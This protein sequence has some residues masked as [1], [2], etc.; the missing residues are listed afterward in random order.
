MNQ[1]L[2]PC[3]NACPVHTDVRGYIAAISRRDYREAYRLITAN[4]PFPAVCAWICH[5][6]CEDACRRA[7][8]DV[9][10][11]IRDL[12]RF[13]V[14]TAGCVQ[15]GAGGAASTG[16]KVAVI[17]GGPAG[18]TAAYD[19]VK[20]GH[21]VI[22]YERHHSPGGHFLSSLPTYRL[23]REMLKRDIEKILAA[24]VEVRTGT[25]IGV[26][27]TVNSLIEEF[28]AV[29]IAAGLWVS[30]GLDLPGLDHPG[31]HPALQ[32]LEKANRGDMSLAGSRVVVIGGGNVAFD[33][34][35]TAVRIG[36][37]D[38]TV[39]CLESREEIPAHRREVDEA[40]EEG[41]RLHPGYGPVEVLIREGKITGTAV[42][43]VRSIYGQD[44]KFNPFL[45]QGR[46]EIIPCDAVVLAVGQVPDLSLLKGSG[47]AAGEKDFLPTDR[48]PLHP[49]APKVFACGEIV[50]GPGLAIAAVASGHRV[51]LAADR[52]LKGDKTH[53]E[54]PVYEVIAPLP[55]GVA[56]K[57]PRRERQK[58]AVL[59][60]EIR[61]KNLLPYELGLSEAAALSEAG[62]C[63]DC[64]LG[65]VVNADKCTACLTCRRVCPYNVPVMEGLSADMPVESCQ[66]CG[67]CAAVCPAGAI[68]ME[69][70]DQDAV[71]NSLDPAL[72]KGRTAVFACSNAFAGNPAGIVPMET[73]GPARVIRI[74][75][76][77][78]LRLEWILKAFENGAARVAVIA[79]AAEECR[80]A[81]D[82]MIL[83]G[84]VSRALALMEQIGI[85]QERLY[86]N[87][88]TFG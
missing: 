10:L 50:N 81:G 46:V 76:A 43:K 1:F 64:G 21:R 24:G 8:V 49:G 78:A 26:D 9:P 87:T 66:A 41:V 60:P 35:R 25:S 69:N 16:K 34:A 44:G 80:Y 77:G 59:P 20:H 45:E 56:G 54:E 2:P 74:P 23:P 62:R 7:A 6:P 88:V 18:L 29:I 40:L 22:V 52:F 61:V 57:V 42:A 39:V 75:T 84:V 53:Q 73:A 72:I 67:I 65:A 55:A 63:L 68:R 58:M 12:K 70:A 36:A 31:A 48:Q 15:A 11:A 28:D 37:G 47:L 14:E 82:R 86:L 79:C 19:L 38:A 33:V 30:R 83:E 71:L 4:N 5:H 27:L 51:A 13:A 85:Q 3:T 32:F 17:G